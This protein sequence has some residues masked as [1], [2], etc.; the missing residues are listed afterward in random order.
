MEL[1]EE[2][3]EIK[4]EIIESRNLMI[5]TDNLIKN[6]AA[7]LKT[8][9]R[10]A[11]QA[12]MIYN[13]LKGAAPSEDAINEFEQLRGR[14]LTELEQTLLGDIVSKKMKDVAQ[15]Q[16]DEGRRA[17]TRKDL[18]KAEAAF[19]K[20]VRYLGKTKDPMLTDLYYD[21]GLTL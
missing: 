17:L 14:G 6:L 1:D 18:E 19:R 21:L 7:D 13:Q 15:M 8:K 10:A 2:I 20:S 4:K 5:K 9:E 3:K 12:L 11:K 16:Y